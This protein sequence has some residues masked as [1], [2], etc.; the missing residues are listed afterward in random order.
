MTA[1]ILM[2]LL[3][4]IAGTLSL[5]VSIADWALGLKQ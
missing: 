5:G 4:A 2:P 3:A 1:R